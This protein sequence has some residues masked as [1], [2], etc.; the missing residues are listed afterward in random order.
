MPP[1]ALRLKRKETTLFLICDPSDSF[2]KL[3]QRAT[4]ALG[5]KGGPA[6]ISLLVAP[7]EG[8][9]EP[10]EYPDASFVSDFGLQDN[11]V[12]FLTTVGEPIDGKL[13]AAF[14]A[15]TL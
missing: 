8:D 11:S 9:K 2:L 5:I 3:K 7:G 10:K 15:G 14:Q 12:V 1:V 6:Q 13:V 4:D